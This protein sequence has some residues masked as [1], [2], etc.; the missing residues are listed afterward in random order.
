[1][2]QQLGWELPPEGLWSLTGGQAKDLLDMI[3]KRQEVKNG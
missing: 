2:G 1:M 3:D